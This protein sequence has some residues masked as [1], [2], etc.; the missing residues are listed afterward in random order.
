MNDAL[1]HAAY[2]AIAA[3]LNDMIVSFEYENQRYWIKRR[4][5]SKKNIWHR[6]QTLAA[7]LMALP[8][9]KSTASNG[10]AMSIHNEANRLIH[11]KK[12]GV[13]VPDVVYFDEQ[14]LV[15]SDE[16][17]QCHQWLINADVNQRRVWLTKAM[18]LILS[19]HRAGVAHGRPMPKDM[20]VKGEQL[21]M[22]DLEEEPQKVMSLT[23]AQARDVWL[24]MNAV[25][26]FFDDEADIDYI[27]TVYLSKGTSDVAQ[28]LT[29]IVKKLRPLSRILSKLGAQRLGR[30]VRQAIMANEIMAKV[31]LERQ[32]P[33]DVKEV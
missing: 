30:D 6:L 20:L 14:I 21:T 28:A 19:I 3:H 13:F 12:A 22:I 26:R 2:D 23:E 4:P 11:L 5:H 16:G 31:L 1:K 25:T 32:I 17:V 24:F 8:V 15:T 7:S 10:G 29:R 27:L 9:F 33:D 18:E